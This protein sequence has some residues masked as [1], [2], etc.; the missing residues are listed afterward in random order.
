M[1]LLG[2][3]FAVI[4]LTITI[5]VPKTDDKS[6]YANLVKNFMFS[7]LICF[8]GFLGSILLLF[9]FSSLIVEIDFFEEPILSFLVF[10]G[11]LVYINLFVFYLFEKRQESS[12]KAFKIIFLYILFPIYGLLLLILYAYLF[13][14]L[15]TLSLPNGQINWFVSFATVFYL[16]FYFIL[17]EYEDLKIIKLFYRFGAL[18]LIPLVCIQWPAYFIRLN[19]YGFTGWRYS[20]LI[21]NIFSVIFIIFT[22][23][24][25]GK[26]TKFAIPVLG[27]FI[28]WT[29]V[30]PFNLIDVAYR[31]QYNRLVDVLKR[32]GMFENGRLKESIPDYINESIS[33]EDR[34]QLVSAHNYIRYKSDHER[35]DWINKAYA[36]KEVYNIDAEKSE[37]NLLRYKMNP[38]E[39]NFAVDI[40]GY[41]T[42]QK[43]N[44]H[45]Y[46]GSVDCKK[47]FFP[48]TSNDISELLLSLEKTEENYFYYQVDESTRAFVYDVE[49]S[50]N[51]EKQGFEGYAFDYYLLKK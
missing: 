45:N 20:S 43:Y 15:F 7:G 42:V 51:K 12:G 16:V 19:S 11:I 1:Y 37:Y 27:V 6:Y 9:A 39:A 5:F 2:I 10:W 35:P 18:V 26:F 41:S 28:L 46:F 34:E 14:A 13:K 38:L 31:S 25:K 8:V 33:D 4:C 47:A 40:K 48:E 24:K 32:N 29:S 17:R 30:T 21:Y 3:A 23:I 50:Y 44:I 49:Y 36:I 22:F